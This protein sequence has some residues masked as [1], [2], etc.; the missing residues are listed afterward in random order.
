LNYT[1][2]LSKHVTINLILPSVRQ[3]FFPF[4]NRPPAI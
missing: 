2:V 4:E 1:R 3:L